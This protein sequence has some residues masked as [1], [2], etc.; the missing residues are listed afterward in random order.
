[1]NDIQIKKHAIGTQE[2]NSINARELW[3]YL[4]SKQQFANWI[5]KRIEK[6]NFQ[7][8]EDYIVNKFINNTEQ[9]KKAVEQIEEKSNFIHPK[10][11]NSL[12][13]LCRS[14]AHA[15]S[16]LENK[17]FMV[18]LNNIQNQIKTKY[19]VNWL[20]DLRSSDVKNVF[21]HV[22][23]LKNAYYKDLSQTQLF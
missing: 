3:K 17:T 23:K 1:M 14:V 12:F 8:N 16:E 7:E 2:I 5:R 19:G 4:E 13:S 11:L 10:E 21:S 18:A 6:Y 9:G 20:E 22:Q 15:K